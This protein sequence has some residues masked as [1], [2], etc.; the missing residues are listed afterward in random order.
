MVAYQRAKD[1]N[2]EVFTFNNHEFVVGY[3]KYMIDYLSKQF[4]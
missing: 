3:A 4:T 2:Q 1:N